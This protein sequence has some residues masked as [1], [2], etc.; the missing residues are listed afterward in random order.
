MVV[1]LEEL[2][3]L[4]ET[5]RILAVAIRELPVNSVTDVEIK[6]VANE[7]IKHHGL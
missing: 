2:E 4:K 3:A 1:V 5:V 6:R 7:R